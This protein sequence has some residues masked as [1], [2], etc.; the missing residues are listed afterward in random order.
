MG[1]SRILR[2]ESIG[3][4][5]YRPRWS[6][7]SCCLCLLRQAR[8][9]FF[10]AKTIERSSF[11]LSEHIGSQ[12]QSFG[13]PSLP[14]PFPLSKFSDPGIPTTTICMPSTQLGFVMGMASSLRSTQM[15]SGVVMSTTLSLQVIRN[16]FLN[17]IL[18]RLP[19][20]SSVPLDV[21]FTDREAA[22][23]RPP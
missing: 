21:D 12:I 14:V 22:V 11:V 16:S 15:R 9:A 4:R 17:Q 19:L 6:I 8:L 18:Y 13:V 23:I 10:S 2:G 3:C 1:N 20:Y 5:N 7:L